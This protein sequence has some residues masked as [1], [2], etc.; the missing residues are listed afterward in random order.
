METVLKEARR[1][2]EE[3]YEDAVAA[4]SNECNKG[5]QSSK[6]TNVICEVIVHVAGY[7]CKLF[8]CHASDTAVPDVG[9]DRKLDCHCATSCTNHRGDRD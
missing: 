4:G 9:R 6:I 7:D 3:E 2:F 1:L 8:S 5:R